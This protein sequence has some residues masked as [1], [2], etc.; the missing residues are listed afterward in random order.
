[1]LYGICEELNST[2]KEKAELS[3]ACFSVQPED[4]IR[5]KQKHNH[6]FVEAVFS[7]TSSVV[8]DL[9]KSEQIKLSDNESASGVAFSQIKSIFITRK[10]LALTSQ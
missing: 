5:N 3:E 1:M 4:L 2:L 10:P 6:A 7:D 8:Y 9:A